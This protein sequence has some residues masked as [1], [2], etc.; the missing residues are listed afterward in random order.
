MPD[1]SVESLESSIASAVPAVSTSAVLKSADF[2]VALAAFL[3]SLVSKAPLTL[4]YTPGCTVQKGAEPMQIG[5]VAKKIG[6]SVDA[7]RFYERNALLPRPPRTQGD[8]KS[9]V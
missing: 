9:V 3:A 8:R 7:I 1:W 4:D 2:V 5:V 6:L